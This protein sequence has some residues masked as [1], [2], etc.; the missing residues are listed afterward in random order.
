VSTC[1]SLAWTEVNEQ[2][3]TSIKEIRRFIV[4]PGME[5][6]T[7]QANKWIFLK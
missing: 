5:R 2:E 3:S 6:F 1:N 7:S 4:P